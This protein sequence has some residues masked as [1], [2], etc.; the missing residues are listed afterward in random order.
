[1][2][3]FL[4]I[5]ALLCLAT[6]VV[7]SFFSFFGHISTELFALLSGSLAVTASVLDIFANKPVGKE[8]VGVAVDKLLL[9]YDIETIEEL[10]EAKEEEQK[11]REF[12]DHRSNEIF[13][14]RLRAYI[15]EQVISKYK[16]SE[17][18]KL[19]GELEQVESQLDTMQV[20]YG[21]IDLPERFKKLLSRLNEEEKFNA[22]VDLIDAFPEFPLI[23][24]KRMY[25]AVLKFGFANRHQIREKLPNSV[26]K[27]V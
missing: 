16:N 15:E 6:I 27:Y 5:L 4:R 10:K 3:K 26:G 7:L 9:T 22:Y 8:E 23:P 24:M 11:L 13:L 20:Q 19:V 14:I 12:I 21:E 17:I 18:A 25:I 1:M 2:S